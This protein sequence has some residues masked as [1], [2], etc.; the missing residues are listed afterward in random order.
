MISLEYISDM[1]QIKDFSAFESS[2]IILESKNSEAELRKEF[3]GIGSAFKEAL[4][5]A[6]QR[7]IDYELSVAEENGEKFPRITIIGLEHPLD[8][9]GYEHQ[10]QGEKRITDIDELQKSMQE[11]AK[12]NG[13]PEP[14]FDWRWDFKYSRPIEFI[15]SFFYDNSDRIKKRIFTEEEVDYKNLP[16]YKAII[17]AG[18]KDITSPSVQKRKTI[19]LSHPLLVDAYKNDKALNGKISLSANGPIRY[20]GESVLTGIVKAGK[21]LVNKDNYIFSLRQAADI[22]ML[23]TLKSIKADPKLISD[24]KKMETEEA[25]KK[26]KSAVSS[27]LDPDVLEKAFGKTDLFDES[28]FNA[29][30]TPEEFE[31]LKLKSKVRS[32]II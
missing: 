7:G 15:K 18:F 9:R 3:P 14:A 31:N 30:L 13:L 11:F 20:S 28:D 17:K 23:K 6:K 19:V 8:L 21:P 10:G 32:M 22:L 1:R 29:V 12:K 5:Y 2:R 24:F 16:I 27:N 25:L 26:F 4:R